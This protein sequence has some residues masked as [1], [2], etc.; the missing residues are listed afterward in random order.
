[1]MAPTLYGTINPPVHFFPIHDIS[2]NTLTPPEFIVLDDSRVGARNT[3]V[4]DGPEVSALQKKAYPDISPI[5]SGMSALEAFD[6]ALR[7][8]DLMGWE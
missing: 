5:E 6:E 2:T 3:L 7:V 1:M 8:A 4:Y